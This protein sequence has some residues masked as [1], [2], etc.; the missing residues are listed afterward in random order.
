MNWLSS[1]YLLIA[2]VFYIAFLKNIA[3]DL[4]PNPEFKYA[5]ILIH[6]FLFLGA[7]LWPLLLILLFLNEKFFN[8]GTEFFNAVKLIEDG[9]KEIEELLILTP[10]CS[11]T[12][13]YKPRYGLSETIDAEFYFHAN[14]VER[15]LDKSNLNLAHASRLNQEPVIHKWIKNRNQNDNKP[16]S[17]PVNLDRFEYIALDLIKNLKGYVYCSACENEYQCADLNIV[18]DDIK[19]SWNGVKVCCPEG[20]LLFY[21]K[22]T[23]ILMHPRD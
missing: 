11:Q 3:C 4:E 17:V 5:K 1:I 19:P 7:I 20:D 12:I 16:T 8:K 23:H 2:L 21:P 6:S 22:T 9:Q 10:Y 15:Y 14:D 18:E 13:S